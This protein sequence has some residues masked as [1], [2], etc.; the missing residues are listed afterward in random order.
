MTFLIYQ[1]TSTQNS[2]LKHN[3][4]LQNQEKEKKPHR[5]E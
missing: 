2:V 5:A 4:A 3:R 1:N